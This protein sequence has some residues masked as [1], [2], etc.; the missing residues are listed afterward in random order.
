MEKW[1]LRRACEDLL[2]PHLVWRRKAQFDEGSGTAGALPESISAV[3][4]EEDA[5]EVRKANPDVPLRSAEEA[6][7]FSVFCDVFAAS[8][9]VRHN[10]ARWADRPDFEALASD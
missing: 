4:S 2:P 5:A 3:F 1:V 9:H 8:P 7:Y 10:V 6:Y